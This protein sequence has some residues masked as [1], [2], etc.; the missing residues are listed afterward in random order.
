MYKELADRLRE[1]AEWAEANE[2]E[3]PITLWD[4]LTHAADAID[5]LQSELN[6]IRGCDWCIGFC[7]DV[8]GDPYADYRYCPMCGRELRGCADSRNC[9][10]GQ[11][12]IENALH[13]IK[14]YCEKH[15]R[16]CD[17][18]FDASDGCVIQK[19][20]PCDWEIPVKGKNGDE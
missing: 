3:T 17:C 16:C 13:R 9:T 4:D 5:K 12:I 2:W 19:T 6:R 10:G 11:S 20:I 15:E 14:G 1:H 18:R 7:P 8:T